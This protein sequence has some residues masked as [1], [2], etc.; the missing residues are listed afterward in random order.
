M[1]GKENSHT[2]KG[3]G[4]QSIRVNQHVNDST[5]VKHHSFHASFMSLFLK[6]ASCDL[7]SGSVTSYMNPLWALAHL[8]A[9]EIRF[10]VFA[11]VV[12][13]FK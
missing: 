8:I 12:I 5:G 4:T 7:N 13:I 10:V 11:A 1:F 9:F 6:L 3:G 2:T